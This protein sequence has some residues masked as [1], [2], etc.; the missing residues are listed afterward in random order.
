MRWEERYLPAVG[1]LKDDLADRS[2]P[3]AVA[4]ASAAL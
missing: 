3:K 4:V 1:E 2:A